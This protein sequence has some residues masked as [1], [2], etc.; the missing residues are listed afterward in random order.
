MKDLFNWIITNYRFV[1]EVVILII[2]VVVFILRKRNYSSVEGDIFSL[3]IKAVNYIEGTELKGTDKLDAAVM[4][5]INELS[6]MYPKADC[7]VYFNFV[8]SVIEKIL[9]TPQKKG[10]K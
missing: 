3:C 9:S 7:G 4:M 5:V 6:K 1:L 10:V 2:S 8:A